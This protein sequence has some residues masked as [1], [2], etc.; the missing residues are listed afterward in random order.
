MTYAVIALVAVLILCLTAI[1]WALVFL[2]R[3]VLKALRRN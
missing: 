2:V 3:L 1:V